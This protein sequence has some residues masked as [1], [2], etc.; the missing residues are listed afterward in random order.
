MDKYRNDNPTVATMIPPP[1][2]TCYIQRTTKTNIDSDLKGKSLFKK[3]FNKSKYTSQTKKQASI[4][5]W[6][7]QIWISRALYI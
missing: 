6:T 4:S 5:V 1:L 3:R 2:P 7:V